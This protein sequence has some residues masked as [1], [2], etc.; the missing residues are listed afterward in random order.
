MSGKNYLFSEIKEK[1]N[2]SITLGD[3]EKC[4]ILGVG[5][6]GKN[7]FKTND[8]VYLVESVKLNL[9][10]VSQLCD[11]GNQVI[12]DKDKCV[13]KNPN[14]GYTFITALRHANAYTLNTTKIAA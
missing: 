7:P 6:V 12:F 8:N 3:K 4:K 5:K 9:L 13:V 1:C 2:G 11:K 14:T 10:S